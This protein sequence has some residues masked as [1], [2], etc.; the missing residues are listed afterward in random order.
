MERRRDVRAAGLERRA[1][2]PAELPVRID[3]FPD[4]ACARRE[5]E[6]ARQALP[7][8][9]KV[10]AVAPH[11]LTGARDH[12]RLVLRVVR[13][14]SRLSGTS[15]VGVRVEDAGWVLGTS[16]VTNQEGEAQQS[17]QATARDRHVHALVTPNAASDRISGPARRAAP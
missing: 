17:H 5:N 2:A 6:V 16:D 7:D 3:S 11:V 8:E 1:N 14:G 9:M 4:E 12:I 13:H 15:D 10:V